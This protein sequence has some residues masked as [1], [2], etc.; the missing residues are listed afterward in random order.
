MHLFSHWHVHYRLEISSVRVWIGMTLRLLAC[1]LADRTA[2][3]CG[4]GGCRCNARVCSCIHCST[5]CEG[6]V[7]AGK[8]MFKTEGLPL[9]TLQKP[10]RW[11]TFWKWANIQQ[12]LGMYC[13]YLTCQWTFQW[14]IY[15]IPRLIIYILFRAWFLPIERSLRILYCC[16]L[17]DLSQ[18][19]HWSW[20]RWAAR[21]TLVCSMTVF[22]CR[23]C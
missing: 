22:L 1:C 23:F 16:Q 7:A 5:H 20:G 15:H 18:N 14:E 2:F 10:C 9:D 19:G 3:R 6:S 11:Q 12:Y 17:G 13:N 21:P 4:R 8:G